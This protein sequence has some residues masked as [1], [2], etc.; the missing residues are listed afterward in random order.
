MLNRLIL[1]PFFILFTCL[2]AILFQPLIHSDVH[3]LAETGVKMSSPKK[4]VVL[5]SYRDGWWAVED[6]NKGIIQGLATM[7]FVEGE[8]IE[9]IRLYMNTKTVNKT[10]VQKENS[11][12]RILRIL[13][14]EKPDILF[15]MDDDALRHVGAKLLDTELPIV[16]G[17]INLL[18][19]DPDYGWVSLNE[20][21]P[22]ADSMEKPG[23]NITGVLERIAI[24]SGF[25]LLHQIVPEAKT[26]LFLSDSSALSQQLLR[27][28]GDSTIFNNLPIE[29]I[30]QLYTDSFSTMQ[31]MVLE[32]QDKVDAIIMFLPWTFEDENGNHIPQERVVRW[33]LKNNSK[34][35]IAYLDILAKEGFL[36]GLVVD[37][38]QQGVHAGIIGGKILGGAD[39]SEIPIIDPVAN[40][41]MINLARSRQLGVDIPFE[42]ISNTD[43]VFQTMSVYPEFSGTTN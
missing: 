9:L 18:V 6:E 30:G 23:H 43:V 36:C 21:V 33:L 28:A 37:M 25:N 26:A 22:L 14:R 35:G 3:L 31:K 32:Y 34:P 10:P 4:A 29:V 38:V 24:R 2:F 17:G 5:F 19:T 8:N 39:P 16:F 11:A 41:I 13:D 7:G 40:R 42:V 27:T 20:R 12:E 15:I 1:L